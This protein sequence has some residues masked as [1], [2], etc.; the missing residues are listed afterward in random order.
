MSSSADIPTRCAR[1]R[2]RATRWARRSTAASTWSTHGSPS[3]PTFVREGLAANEDEYLAA[4]GRELALLWHAPGYL[5]SSDIIAA[6]AAMRY[7]YVGRDLDP[8]DWISRADTGAATGLYQ[9]AADLVERVVAAKR[10]GS[11]VPV[12]VGPGTG[13]R[14]DYLFQKLDLLVNELVRLGYDIVPVSTLIEH[15]R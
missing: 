4:T 2:T 14:D 11:I 6:G 15:A 12:L 8:K 5:V 13:S 9:S 3:T 10:P 7:T 1:S